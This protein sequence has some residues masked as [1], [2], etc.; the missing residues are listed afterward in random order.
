[1]TIVSYPDNNITSLVDLI[2]YVNKITEVGGVGF[3]GIA[4]LIMIAGVSFFSSKAYSFSKALGFS[5]FLTMLSGIFLRFL[6][7]INDTVLFVVI[8]LFIFSVVL[9]IGEDKYAQT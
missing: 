6:N 5:M 9:L 7:L 4:I 8:V 1:M 2:N 3:F